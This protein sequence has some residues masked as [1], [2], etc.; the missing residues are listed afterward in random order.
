MSV[1]TGSISDLRN[2][3]YG[4]KTHPFVNYYGSD[5]NSQNSNP[6]DATIWNDITTVIQNTQTYLSSSGVH[7]GGSCLVDSLRGQ[8]Q[9]NP[10]TW[11]H[12]SSNYKI[13][14]QASTADS[15][16]TYVN[17]YHGEG[18]CVDLNN[19]ILNVETN[20]PFTYDG[21][22]TGPTAYNENVTLHPQFFGITWNDRTYTGIYMDITAMIHD[23]VGVLGVKTVLLT[24][25]Y[26]VS[27]TASLL[28]GRN[29]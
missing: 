20:I 23:I 28:K 16:T 1:L 3:V 5:P 15:I 12:L 27:V 19:M 7:T 17:I 6:V 29:Y 9:I 14:T 10:D 21:G 2:N 4:V 8:N 13:I 18:Y 26:K 24:G 25:T 11:K 22:N